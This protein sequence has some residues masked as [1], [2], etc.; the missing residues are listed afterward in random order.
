MVG[1][2]ITLLLNAPNLPPIH[3]TVYP[4]TYPY[5]LYS[6]IVDLISKLVYL[7]G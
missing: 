6:F 1:G 3:D 7:L 2:K 5:M 4:V